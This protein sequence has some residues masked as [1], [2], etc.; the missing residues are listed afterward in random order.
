MYCNV[1][2]GPVAMWTSSDVGLDDVMCVCLCLTSR[3]S[4]SQ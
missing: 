4:D 3:R 1:L 2:S